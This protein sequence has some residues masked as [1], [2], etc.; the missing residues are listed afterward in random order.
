MIWSICTAMD[1]DDREGL[2]DALGKSRGF[3]ITLAL[4]P[5][6]AEALREWR[7]RCCIVCG[8]YYVGGV[9]CSRCVEPGEPLERPQ[10]SQRT[11]ATALALGLEIMGIGGD[12]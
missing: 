3:A 10:D 6:E 9:S 5:H 7:D 12:G 1:D 11:N 8:Y 2:A 4:D